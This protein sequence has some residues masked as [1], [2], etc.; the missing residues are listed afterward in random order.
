MTMSEARRVTIGDVARASKTSV[1][2]VS[3]VLR[4][5]PGIGLETRRRVLEAARV[6]GYRRQSPT[7]PSPGSATRTI[8][9]ILRARA[10][11]RDVA[12]PIVNPFYSWVVAGVDAAAR[13]QRLNLLY[14]SVPVD[15]ENRP[16]DLPRYLLDQPL[17]GLLL[18]GAFGDDAIDEIAGGRSAPVV[19]VDAPGGTHH[20][21][22]VVSDNEGGAYGAVS[23]LVE[24]GHR[25]IALVAPHPQADPVFMQRRAGYL[26]AIRE[27]GLADYAIGDA[28]TPDEAGA[29]VAPLL[30]QHPTITAVFAS[31]DAVAIAA[32]RTAQSIG[33]R[34]PDNLSVIG[35]DDIEISGQTAPP[36]TTMAVDKLSMGILGVQL[37]IHRLAWPDAAVATT[38]LQPRLIERASTAPPAPATTHTGGARP[39]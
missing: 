2:T 37:L 9:L 34:V 26:R 15:Q 35:F 7:P 21:D 3:L 16:I 14:A 23:H 13:E 20:F 39:A 24:L 22:A 32:M 17:D 38:C 25:E 8:G 27:H 31:N 11:S 4:S 18:V 29:A 5:K 12:L 1:S 30:Q 10:R 28:R 6:L 36:L 19:L 33:R